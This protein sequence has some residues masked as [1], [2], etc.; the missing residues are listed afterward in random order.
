LTFDN[1]KLRRRAAVTSIFAASCLV[2]AKLIAGWLTHSLALISEAGHSGADLAAALV[3]YVAVRNASKPPD[4]EHHFGHA[5][6]ESIGALL[7]VSFLVLIAMVIV[8]SAMRRLLLGA[9]EI[10]LTPT[11]IGLVA[12]SV[13]VDVWR[14]VTLRR[15]ARRTGSEA[16]EAS[17]LHFLS[18]LLGTSVVVF[19]LFMSVFG[20][21]K[22]DSIAALIIAAIILFLAVNLGLRIFHSLTDRAPEGMAQNVARIVSGVANVLGVHDIRIRQAGSQYFTEMHIDLAQHLPL[23]EVHR[24]LDR[25]EESLRATYPTMHIVT[26]PEPV[27]TPPAGSSFAR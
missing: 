6:Y 26:H 27:D 14:T 9:P 8:Y 4:S 5:K 15:A 11:A 1:V 21:P 16:L 24:V 10:T 23:G 19:G 20:F 18:D 7:E 25:I 17:S 22:A 12:F 3:T 2:V 13:S